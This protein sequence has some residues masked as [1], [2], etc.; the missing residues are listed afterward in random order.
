M[1]DARARALPGR[2]GMLEPRASGL[3]GRPG[4]PDARAR[5]LARRSGAPQ[6]RAS[7]L[8]GRSGAPD[9][10]ASAF[11][12]RSSAPGRRA[13]ALGRRSG[14]PGHFSSGDAGARRTP[15]SSIETARRRPMTT[16]STRCVP[17]VAAA[18]STVRV[19]AMSSGLGAGS[20]L[21]WSVHQH[22]RARRLAERDAQ[23]VPGGDM[24]AVDAARGDLA[25]RAQA[26]V[27]VEREDPQLFVI[28][29]GQARDGPRL[30]R[31][32]VRHAGRGLERRRD[33]RAPPELHRGH[34]ARGLGD[35]HARALRQLADAGPREAGDAPVLLEQQHREHADREA[36]PARSEHQRHELRVAH[37]LDPDGDRALARAGP[38]LRECHRRPTTQG[39]C[40]PRAPCLFA[41]RGPRRPSRAGSRPSADGGRATGRPRP[42]RP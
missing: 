40:R 9:A 22:E 21:G 31:R 13:R 8:A 35:P 19:N 37:V 5:A 1:P 10:R 6:P 3:P 11:P 15:A 20:P 36:L 41:E 26:V 2:P 17:M 7:G 23:R 39:A 12:G 18:R 28:E 29:R 42:S 4:A 34:E 32:P 16:W 30:D 33:R 25:R 38:Q 24:E 14:A 27:P